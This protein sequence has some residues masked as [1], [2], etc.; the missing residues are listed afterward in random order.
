MTPVLFQ[1]R[2]PSDEIENSSFSAANC[3]EQQKLVLP[4]FD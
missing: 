1:F 4:Q 3:E 2:G